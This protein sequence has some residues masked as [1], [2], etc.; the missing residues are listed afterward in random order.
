M[1]PRLLLGSS[2]SVHTRK[3][4][5]PD[6]ERKGKK[7]KEMKDEKYIN[8]KD[9]SLAVTPTDRAVKT[10]TKKIRTDR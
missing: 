5:K 6:S 10:E 2:A 4:K 8:E 9:Q 7:K 1:Q 3:Q